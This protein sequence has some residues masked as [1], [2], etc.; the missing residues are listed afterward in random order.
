MY[1]NKN[2]KCYV[3]SSFNKY[4]K[5][6]CCDHIV[7]E[8]SLAKKILDYINIFLKSINYDKIFSDFESVISKYIL[9]NKITQE[10]YNLFIS[11]IDSFL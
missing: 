2:R 10:N 7:R 5:K 3:Y 9:D 4:G 1:F 8:K 6:A 11:E